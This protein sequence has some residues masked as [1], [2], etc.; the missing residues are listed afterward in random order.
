MKEKNK[1]WRS[2]QAKEDSFWR[3]TEVIGSQMDRVI[4][5]YGPVIKRLSKDLKPDAK[6]LDVGCGP[7]CPAQLFT[8]GSRVYLDPLMDSY[9]RTYAERLPQGK[10]ICAIAES[11][12][13][14]DKIF[15]L[16]ICVNALDHMI[17]PDKVLDE[18]NRV[19]KEGGVFVLGNFLHPPKIAVLRTWIEK[20]L[21]LFREDAHPFSYTLR[22]MKKLIGPFFRIQE[23]IRVFR[24]DSA[25]FP[26]IHREDWLFICRKNEVL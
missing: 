18:I 26:S 6:I 23:E 12:P 7:T 21:P 3:R 22:S 14:R 5:R 1:R 25:L 8:T 10:M 4:S 17:N 2:A 9:Q 11:I 13:L 15:D 19:L 20:W 24:K 16:V